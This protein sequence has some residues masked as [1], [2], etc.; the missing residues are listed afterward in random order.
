MSKIP[1]S[2]RSHHNNLPIIG[3]MF[4]GA[5]G[6]PK[7]EKKLKEMRRVQAEIEKSRP[8]EMQ[9]RLNA[10]RN[11]SLAFNPMQKL[12]AQMYGGGAVP[13]IQGMVNAPVFSQNH[14]A[15]QGPST[16]ELTE[17]EKLTA[18]KSK[19]KNIASESGKQGRKQAFRIATE[20]G[21]QGSSA[22]KRLRDR[23]F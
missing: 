8:I 18:G 3:G 21:K 1:D 19:F 6:D 15:F 14:P 2:I 7:K 11:A 20:G 16:P 13:D 17:K 9:T 4:E 5:W 22:F 12:M 23:I 10:M